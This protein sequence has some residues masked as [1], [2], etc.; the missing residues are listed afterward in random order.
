[1]D[2]FE[3]FEELFCDMFLLRTAIDG[4]ASQRREEALRETARD[5]FKRLMDRLR[6]AAL[7]TAEE[8]VRRHDYERHP[9]A[10]PH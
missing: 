10:Q 9:A 1:M 5:S 7:V 3:I 8:E 4:G 6:L 2:D